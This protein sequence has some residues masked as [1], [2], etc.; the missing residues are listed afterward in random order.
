MVEI[1]KPIAVRDAIKRVMDKANALP[2]IEITLEESYGYILAEPI[3]AMHDVPSFNNSPYDGFAIRSEDSIGASGDNRIHFRVIDHIGAGQVSK[4]ALGRYEA[5]RIMTG[6]PIPEGADAVVMLEQTVESE[7]TFT[8]RKPFKQLENISLQGE[9]SKKGEML[10][11]L[12][13]FIHP[14]TIALLATFG[15]AKVKVRKNQLSV[16][17]ALGQSF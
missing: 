12:G 16:F 14:G 13:T 17:F 5:V 3:I 9:D 15:Y 8:I 7:N 4:H 2:I 10:I 6:A 11:P 1:R